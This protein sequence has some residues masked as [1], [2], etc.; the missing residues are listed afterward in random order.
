MQS[1]VKSGEFTVR[2]KIRKA[3][4][5]NLIFYGIFFFLSCF[6]IF[7]MWQQDEFRHL[8]F[9]GFVIAMSNA[10]GLFLIIVFLGY[11]LVTVPKHCFRMVSINR[12]YEYQMF[13]V[14]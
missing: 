9:Q 6:F 13:R 10:W 5:N 8:S 2:G 7:Y 4:V 14:A 11:G 1:Y 3:I 12:M